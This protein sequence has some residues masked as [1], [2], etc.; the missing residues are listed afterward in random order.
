MQKKKQNNNNVHQYSLKFIEQK[1]KVEKMKGCLCK[2]ENGL[3]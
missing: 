1:R 2:L 3:S